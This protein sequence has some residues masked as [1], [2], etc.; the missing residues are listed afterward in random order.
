MACVFNK[1][2]KLSSFNYMTSFTNY[3]PK[4]SLTCRGRSVIAGLGTSPH[5][6]AAEHQRL[7]SRGDVQ[8]SN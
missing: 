4:L 6:T 8:S 2:S 3:I 5:V 7:F 1:S